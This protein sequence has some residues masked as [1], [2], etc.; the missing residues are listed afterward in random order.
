MTL[1]YLAAGAVLLGAYALVMILAR[2]VSMADD[3][4]EPDWDAEFAKYVRD[5]ER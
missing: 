4:M 1:V 2:A 5:L 3:A